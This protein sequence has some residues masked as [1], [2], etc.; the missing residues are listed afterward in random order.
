MLYTIYKA[1]NKIDHKVYIGFD[2]KWPNRMRIHKSASK[3]Q[4]TKF[5]RAIRKYGWDSFIWEPIYQSTDKEYTLNIME[6]TF[7]HEY[8]SYHNGYNA[9]LGGDGCFG[10]VLNEDA[11]RRISDGNKI[12]KPQTPDH[13]KNI[14]ISLKKYYQENGGPVVSEETKAKISKALKGKSKPMSESHKKNLKCHTNNKLKVSCPHC[15]KVGQFT[16][17]KRWHFDNCR[18][19]QSPL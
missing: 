3:T 15:H 19:V 6:K 11:R 1:T 18:Q 13:S 10:L 5:Y 4:D 12:P 17:M 7:I 9:T 2:S 8:D 14:S 16:N